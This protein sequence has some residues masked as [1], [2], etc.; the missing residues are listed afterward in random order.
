[1]IKK[2]ILIFIYTLLVVDVYSQENMLNTNESSEHRATQKEKE[3]FLSI[4]GFFEGRIGYRVQN[5]QNQDYISISEFRLQLETEK[6]L[7]PF[8][9]NVVS[10]FVL[11]PIIMEDAE[12][13]YKTNLDVGVG[14]ID[15][16]QANIMFSPFKFSDVKIGRQI[17]TWGTGDLIFINDLFA[18]DWKSFFIGRDDEYLKAPTDAIKVSIFSKVVNVDLIYTPKFGADRFIDGDRISFFDR[19][20]NAFR[21][22]DSPMIVNKP[23][24]WF[25]DDEIAIRAYRS[26]GAYEA[27]LY[28]YNGFWK[29]PAGQ[30]LITQNAT[31]PKL[32]VY[33]ASFRG[34]LA[35]GILSLEGG[36]YKNDSESSNNTFVRNDEL[37]LLAGYEKEIATEFTLG[38]QYNLEQKLDYDEYVNSLPN[39]AIQ[40]DEHRHIST[41]RL[42]K[43]L[44]QQDLK[45]SLFNYYSPS[46]EDGYLR[47]QASYKISDEAKI[48][49]GGN[50][51]YG[52][53]NHT[54]FNQFNNNNNVYVGFR[55]EF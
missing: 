55:Y 13:I 17:L 16:R 28:Y 29:S 46:D 45:L 12:D 3:P 47:L 52:R 20:L 41:L 22:E 6:E 26:F 9:L 33:G 34:S 2:I 54:F 11:D 23:D 48:D 39:G 38:I 5:D 8:T 10:D 42:T 31:F 40:D 15:L 37:R 14:L 30:D 4:N 35:K 43:L 18:K 44:M 24:T 25:E 32:E 51:F 7:G 21:G 53:D 27:A 1:M 19:S 50:F 36:Y 49:G